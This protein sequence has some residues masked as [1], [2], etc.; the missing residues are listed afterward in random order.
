[1]EQTESS[2]PETAVPPMDTDYKTFVKAKDRRQATFTLVA[3]DASADLV[4]DFWTMVQIRARQSM[5]SGLTLAEAMALE[6][7]AFGIPAYVPAVH[8]DPKLAGASVIAGN[9]RQFPNRKMAD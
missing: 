8:D 5:E 6:R 7:I 9:M 1:M 2:T 4:V 3:Q